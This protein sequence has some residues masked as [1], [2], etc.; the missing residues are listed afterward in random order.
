MGKKGHD[1]ESIPLCLFHHRMEHQIGVDTF[2][3]IVLER[4]GRTRPQWVK[5]F[6]KRY[7]G[8]L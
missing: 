7:K 5:S 6:Q 3:D 8:A 4:T 1:D 2:G